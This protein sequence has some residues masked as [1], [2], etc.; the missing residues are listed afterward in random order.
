MWQKMSILYGIESSSRQRYGLLILSNLRMFS[1]L[2]QQ[3][4]QILFSNSLMDFWSIVIYD[5]GRMR[6]RVVSILLFFEIILFYTL[7]IFL[8]EFNG[9][10]FYLTSNAVLFILSFY[11]NKVI[12][13]KIGKNS[14]N[15]IWTLI[16]FPNQFRVQQCFQGLI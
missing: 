8:Q 12:L 4:I 5:I 16:Q 7:F 11:F 10:G 15:Q 13:V 14:V 2:T 9:I 1:F 6:I 3:G